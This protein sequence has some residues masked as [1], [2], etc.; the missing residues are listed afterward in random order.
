[1]R[2][3]RRCRDD[4]TRL[5]QSTRSALDPVRSQLPTPRRPFNA[6]PTS[7][8]R[9]ARRRGP[10]RP[11]S[12]CTAMLRRHA[13]PHPALR[14]VMRRRARPRRLICT[15]APDPRA[16]ALPLRA[17][18]HGGALLAHVRPSCSAAPASHASVVRPGHLADVR[19]PTPPRPARTCAPAVRRRAGLA[20]VRPMCTDI[21]GR[22]RNRHY[23]TLNHIRTAP[24]HITLPAPRYPPGEER[25]GL[26]LRAI[27]VA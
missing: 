16:P 4:V 27:P 25:D 12:I 1:M 6:R 7:W 15:A 8:P 14:S 11:I 5:S 18:K 2:P 20:H 10:G 23:W 3:G 26:P 17:A 19:P 21:D 9:R 13:Q 24:G 22:H